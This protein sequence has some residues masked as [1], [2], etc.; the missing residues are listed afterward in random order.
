MEGE[1]YI[2][3]FGF[4][5]VFV[6][7]GLNIFNMVA[8][9]QVKEHIKYNKLPIVIKRSVSSVDIGTEMTKINESK[10]SSEDDTFSEG[11]D[12]SQIEVVLTEETKEDSKIDNKSGYFTT[13]FNKK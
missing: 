4:S 9:K 13:W 7:L 12:D 5:L 2:Y 11:T 10:K 1:L 3:V 8:N 6:N